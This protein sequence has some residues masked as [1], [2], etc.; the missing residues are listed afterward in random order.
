M[1]VKDV[2]SH[3]PE[4]LILCG[5]ALMFLSLFFRLGY[6]PWGSELSYYLLLSWNMHWESWYMWIPAWPVAFGLIQALTIGLRFLLPIPITER[7]RWIVT[8]C[9]LVTVA[10]AVV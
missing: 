2:F 6:G 1:R 3:P 8:S 9:F 7:C 10:V 5:G 4:R